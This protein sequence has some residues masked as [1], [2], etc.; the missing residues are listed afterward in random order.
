MFDRDSLLRLVKLLG[1][2]PD[3][4]GAD[5]IEHGLSLLK[6]LRRDR[7]LDE[8]VFGIVCRYAVHRAAFD[9]LSGKIRE[10]AGRQAADSEKGHFLS[11][12]EQ[13]R[14]FHENKL[15]AIE[16]ELLATP[17]QRAKAGV[18]QQTSFMEQLDAAP[19]EQGGGD[20]VSP[21]AP[22]SRNGRSG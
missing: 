20:K 12:E 16:R 18:A 7:L 13:S 3:Y 8:G 14:A 10:I 5:E 15:V 6:Q 11:P 4:F 1:G 17:Y 21:F 9:R 19:K 22:M 2:W